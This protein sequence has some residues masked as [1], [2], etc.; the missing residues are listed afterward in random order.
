MM[1]LRALWVT[2]GYHPQVGGLE[3]VVAESIDALSPLCDVHLLTG[4][5]QCPLPGQRVVHVGALNLANPASEEIFERTG[6]ELARLATKWHIDVVHFA[7]AGVACYASFLPRSLPV[8]VTVHCKDLTRPWQRVPPGRNVKA[9]IL[10]GLRRAC[11]VFC[12]SAYTKRHVDRIAEG[13][14]AAE[15]LT[16][17]IE[18]PSSE[19]SHDGVDRHSILTIGRA[20]WRKGHIQLLRALERLDGEF[21]WD[22]VGGGPCLEEIRR[23]VLASPIRHRVQIHGHLP[24]VEVER[25]WRRAAV[26]ALTPIEIADEQGI[27]AEGFGLVY[28]E[29][30]IRG[31]P[32]IASIFGGCAD[33]VEHGAT[34]FLVDPH[35]PAALAQT[36]ACLLRSPHERQNLGAAGRLRA[37]LG[38]RW[39]DRAQTLLRHYGASASRPIGGSSS[40]AA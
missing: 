7:S 13:S 18:L 12:V 29:A 3:K 11:R 4:A 10:E 19:E 22:V 14:V 17:G 25:L 39:E 5:G 6:K 36:V 31:I 28:L 2:S 16:P 26:F 1:R 27:D 32:G 33:A 21:F 20:V 8:F 23:Q 24:A 40:Q 35:D 30:A 37:T 34:G 15:V 38:F 9:L